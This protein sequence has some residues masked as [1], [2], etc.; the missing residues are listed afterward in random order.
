MKRNL[1]GIVLMI[2]LLATAGCAWADPDLTIADP[3]TGSGGWAEEYRQI[4]QDRS[5]GI[6]DYRAYVAEITYSGD[7]HP[8]GL[9]DL[10]GDGIP[11]LLFVEQVHDTE[12]GF[13]LGRLWIY[14]ADSRGV[15]CA[16]T[17]TPETDDLMYSS[18]FLGKNGQL[19]IHLNDMEMGW[20][21]Q[22]E[23]NQSGRYEAKTTL[24]SQEDFSGEGPDQYFQNGKSITASA[25]QKKLEEIRSTEG[26]MIGGF[27]EETGF[28][29]FDYTVEEATE[30]LGSGDPTA[31]AGTDA[32]SGRDE[33]G[34]APDSQLPELTFFRGEFTPGDK[35]AVYTAPSA[36]SWRGANG[37]ASITSASEIFVAGT[38][39]GWLLVRY[40]LD[41][42]VIRVGYVDTKK[43]SGPYSSGSELS[44]AALPMKLTEKAVMTDD[45]INQ[46][47]K[48][49]SLKKGASVTCL[50]KYQGMIYVETKVSGKTAR[51]FVPA[52]SLGLD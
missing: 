40:E 15:Y 9:T 47:T 7:A 41:S 45:P 1:C 25:Y 32:G 52:A 4:L 50:A 46:G 35:F 23:R 37:K 42:G 44:F 6:Q 5:A 21:L 2:I 3:E 33:N 49:G 26:T 39:D 13:E 31:A 19:T 43:I 22:L 14:T 17:L 10:T 12:Y 16:L 11:E 27:L 51:G 28:R 20:T 24:V 18:M 34:S 38:V 30:R 36:R 8:V 48:I 29:G